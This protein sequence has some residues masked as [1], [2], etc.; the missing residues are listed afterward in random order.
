MLIHS[1]ECLYDTSMLIHMISFPFFT[2]ISSIVTNVP[3][4]IKGPGNLTCVAL[5]KSKR[6]NGREEK[7]EVE[8]G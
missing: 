3:I 4:A 1:W 5:P 2:A 8:K 7:K 6:D